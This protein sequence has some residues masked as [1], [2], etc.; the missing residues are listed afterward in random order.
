MSDTIG[1]VN[2]LNVIFYYA[3]TDWSFL[4]LKPIQCRAMVA[5]EA[6]KPLVI[7]TVEV[8]PP[9]AGNKIKDSLLII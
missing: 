4:L 7:E 1:K 6:K 9:K 3:Y 2:C 8:S 5:W